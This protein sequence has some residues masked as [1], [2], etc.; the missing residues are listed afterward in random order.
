MR[1]FHFF[2]YSVLDAWGKIPSSVFEGNLYELGGFSE[3]FHIERD[4]AA[5]K[6]QYCLGALVLTLK[7]M[8]TMKSHLFEPRNAPNLLKTGKYKDKPEIEQ[9]MGMPV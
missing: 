9:L 2:D 4:N 7:G 8:P 5:Y 6:T 1:S 3:C